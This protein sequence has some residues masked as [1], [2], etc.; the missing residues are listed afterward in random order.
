MENRIEFVTF[1]RQ[2]VHSDPNNSLFGWRDRRL[3]WRGADVRCSV[4]LCI[5]IFLFFFYRR[6]KGFEGIWKSMILLIFGEFDNY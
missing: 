3:Q 1:L 4:N 5:F 6:G 2:G